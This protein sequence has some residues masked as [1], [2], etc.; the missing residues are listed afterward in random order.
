M[1]FLN[2][3][4][5]LNKEFAYSK[6][7]FL[8]SI[9]RLPSSRIIVINVGLSSL[10]Y[11]TGFFNIRNLKNFISDVAELINSDSK[12]RIVIVISDSIK[13]TQ[14]QYY[15]LQDIAKNKKQFKNVDSNNL[16]ESTSKKTNTKNYIL[17]EI[18]ETDPSLYAAI[19]SMVHSDIV[20]L[21]YDGFSGYNLRTIG[22]SISSNGVDIVG[23]LKRFLKDIERIAF[24]S[25]IK[26]TDKINAI[27]SLFHN[28]RN[29]T[30]TT[31][32]KVVAKKTAETI[33]GLFKAYPRTIPIIMEDISQKNN[34][35]E[36]DDGF[37]AKIAIATNADVMI[38]ISRKG[39]LYT[40]DPL[41][42]SKALP[43]YCYDTSR[44]APFSEI[45]KNN[46]S[47]K[48]AAAKNINSHRRPIPMLLTAYNSPYTIYN[49][50]DF[51]KIS[52]ICINGEFPSFTIF[53]NTDKIDTYLP[54]ERRQIV[55]KIFIDK[56]AADALINKS[57]LLSVGI[58]LINGSFDR[59]ATVAILDEK[60]KEMGKGIVDYSSEELQ[61]H[62]ELHDSVTVINRDRMRI[63]DYYSRGKM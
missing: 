54:I 3:F 25:S 11:N 56:K 29:I 52:N 58:T 39:M 63:N 16:I 33:K 19:V 50:F 32:F 20:N 37:A 1:I 60:E 8:Y 40:V 43:F 53:I 9:N 41:E 13:N 36:D 35:L 47:Q 27:Q 7:A 55:G 57:S 30:Q 51:D 14:Q 18:M 62:L 2:F 23:E 61:Q 28:N 17:Q 31:G 15:A 4:D 45:R 34:S 42:N 44:N 26:D 38:S 48:L 22:F 24:K 12:K 6:E 46:L 49:M 10:T 21:F 59:K 5:H